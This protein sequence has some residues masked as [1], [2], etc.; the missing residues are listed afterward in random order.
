LDSVFRLSDE[1]NSSERIRIEDIL[2]T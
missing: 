1:R 2:D